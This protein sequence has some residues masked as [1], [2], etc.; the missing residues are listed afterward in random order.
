MSTVSDNFCLDIIKKLMPKITITKVP[1]DMTD[2]ALVT[3]I[4]DKEVFLI[5]EISMMSLFSDKI[6]DN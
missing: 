4:C 6:L 1:N 5:S 3:K 2:E